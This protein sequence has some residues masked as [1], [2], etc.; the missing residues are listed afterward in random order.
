MGTLHEEKTDLTRKIEENSEEEVGLEG[1]AQDDL[2]LEREE[3]EEEETHPDQP[4]RDWH[5]P[6]I[7]RK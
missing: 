3:D 2:R 5:E 6:P 1:T 7:E 4:A